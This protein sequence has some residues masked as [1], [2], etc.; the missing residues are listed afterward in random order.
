MADWGPTYND[1]DS[2]VPMPGR[3]IQIWNSIQ[4]GKDGDEAP[5]ELATVSALAYLA[6]I[7]GLAMAIARNQ[8]ND[9]LARATALDVA[10]KAAMD[11][12]KVGEENER[13]A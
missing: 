3:Y 9:P 1:E 5:P 10:R 8:N 13:L 12:A 4:A 6:D 11:Q 7:A 2:G